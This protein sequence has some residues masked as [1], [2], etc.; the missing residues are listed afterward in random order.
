MKCMLISFTY[1]HSFIQRV[2]R[3]LAAITTPTSP[4]M[5]DWPFRITYQ[6]TVSI[7]LHLI[8]TSREFVNHSGV[9]D[10]F[11]VFPFE[12]YMLVIRRTIT[13]KMTC[14]CSR[15]FDEQYHFRPTS[16]GIGQISPDVP[17]LVYRDINCTN[18]CPDNAI[19]IRNRPSFVSDIQ[20]IML[21]IRRFTKIPNFTKNPLP[22]S[23]IGIVSCSYLERT[24]TTTLKAEVMRK[25]FLL[26]C[27]QNW[28]FFTRCSIAGG[29]NSE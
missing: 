17:G 21:F 1:Q 27:D 26:P 6:F 3:S 12:S 25:D 10:T 24:I 15:Y 11:S 18:Q 5:H 8:I 29:W 23:H 20:G 13:S 2:S 9:L 14:R 28:I 7:R 19:P 4:N 22:T 16:N